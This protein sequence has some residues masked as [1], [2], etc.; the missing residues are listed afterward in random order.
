MSDP[1]TAL[2]DMITE[3]QE[4]KITVVLV[5]TILTVTSW[6]VRESSKILN[7][8]NAICIVYTQDKKR[9]TYKCKDQRA[10]GGVHIC[11]VANVDLTWE[12]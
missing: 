2:S 1:H 8:S 3:I 6:S 12:N 10:K 4:W 9:A 7:F 11:T 5:Y